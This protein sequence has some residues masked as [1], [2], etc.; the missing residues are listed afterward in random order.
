MPKKQKSEDRDQRTED[1]DRRTEDGIISKGNQKFKAELERH[2]ANLTAMA[3]ASLEPRMHWNKAGEG[4]PVKHTEG[5]VYTSDNDL[6]LAF[7]D[8]ARGWCTSF[9]QIEG[10]DLVTHWMEIIPPH[11]TSNVPHSTI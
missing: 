6:Y 1:G 5:L 7:Y 3:A 8:P 4:L 9:S 11:S 10:N 2:N